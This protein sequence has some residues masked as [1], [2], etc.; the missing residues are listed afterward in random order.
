MYAGNCREREFAAIF[1]GKVKPEKATQLLY[2]CVQHAQQ[3]E[4]Q[5][6]KSRVTSCCSVNIN[7]Y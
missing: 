4:R 6:S 3:Y 2:F 5:N 1:A 7:V